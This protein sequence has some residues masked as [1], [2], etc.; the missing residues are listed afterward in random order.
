MD[1]RRDLRL[2]LC[3]PRFRIDP[4][5]LNPDGSCEQLSYSDDASACGWDHGEE[6]EE[7]ED[8]DDI[9]DDIEDGCDVAAR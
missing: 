8:H 5:F 3:G 7:E 2:H 6:V 9:T 1:H 4:G